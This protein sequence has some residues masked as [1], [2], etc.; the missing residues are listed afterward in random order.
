MKRL[1]ALFLAVSFVISVAGC[2]PKSDYD[3][4]LEEKAAIQRK[5]DTL[6]SQKVHAESKLSAQEK[7]IISMVKELKDTREKTRDMKKE[8]V[9]AKAKIQALEK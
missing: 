2:T 9:K 4:L 1:L 5:C 8:L 7:Q 6:S 3:K